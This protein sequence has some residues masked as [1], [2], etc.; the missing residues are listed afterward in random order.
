MS[1]PLIV[2]VIM[3][4]GAG[5]RLWPLSRREKPKQM[6]PIFG[7]RSLLQETALRVPT[8][9]GFAPPIVVCAAAHRDAVAEQL[10]EIGLEPTQI[11]GEPMARNTAPCAAI[12]A[13]A[14]KQQFGPDALILLLAADHYFTNPIAFRAAVRQGSNIASAGKILTFGP[15]PTRPETGY[16][17]LQ[18]GPQIEDGIF[19]V[20][21]FV[22]KPDLE[23]AKKWVQD[24]RYLW[25]AGMFLFRAE[26]M[27][28]E[29]MAHRPAIAKAAKAAWQQA[30]HD[31]NF[32]LLNASAFAGCPSE[33]VDT[34][35]MENTS[36]AAVIPLDAGW[37]DVGSWTAIHELSTQDD[38]GNALDGAVT[39]IDNENCLFRA[40]GIRVAAL[41]LQG[42]AVI[43]SPDAVL[44]LPLSEAQRVKELVTQIPEDEL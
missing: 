7:S 6:H 24:E 9:A 38:H 19:Q 12:A 2:P 17:Y 44:V 34:A 30:D 35:V 33:S 40:D 4:G 43:A 3:S 31:G 14:V 18:I 5:T 11:I 42:L 15:K 20:G 16:G 22:E 27:I 23:T 26:P 29:T 1:N 8:D 25:N 21:Q 13:H 28:N 10:S 36:F 32:T 41:G 37:S 39:S